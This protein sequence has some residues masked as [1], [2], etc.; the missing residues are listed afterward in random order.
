[1]LFVQTLEQRTQMVK[2]K[3]KQ[4]IPTPISILRRTT[5][6][7]GRGTKT[8]EILKGNKVVSKVT[9]PFTITECQNIQNRTFTKGL[10]KSAERKTKKKM[11]R[12]AS[13]SKRD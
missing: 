9:E 2:G 11:K 1:M 7:N 8:V 12:I 5:F 13:R 10:F 6:R 4:T 3:G